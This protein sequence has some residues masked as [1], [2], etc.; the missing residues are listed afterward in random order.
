MDWRITRLSENMVQTDW[1]DFCR[2][3]VPKEGQVLLVR[4][5]EGSWG[6]RIIQLEIIDDD[7]FVI[8]LEDADGINPKD[9]RPNMK[10]EIHE[11]VVVI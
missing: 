2:I 10:F 1:N 8:V 4:L 11:A 7:D 9:L 5:G 6:K 3:Y